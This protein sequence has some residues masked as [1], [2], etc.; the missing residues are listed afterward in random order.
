MKLL[1]L[2]RHAR[3]EA[4]SASGLDIDRRLDPSGIEDAQ[5]LGMMMKDRARRYDLRLSSPA[6]RAVETA[7]QAGLEPEL[8]QRIYE[9]GTGELLSIVQSVD[10]GAASV[11]LI[12]HNPGFEHLASLLAGSVVPMPTG[13]LVE[14]ELA[15]EHWSET[16]AGVGQVRRLVSPR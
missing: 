13:T 8:D 12:G 3:A 15:I 14:L 6:S 10:D 1:A 7:R 5:A 16:A 9:A 4:S 11:L 2:L